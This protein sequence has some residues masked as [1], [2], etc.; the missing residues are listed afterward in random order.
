[1]QQIRATTAEALYLK[2]SDLHDEIEPELETLLLET[3]WT[4]EGVGEVEAQLV[5]E[6]LAPN[7][8]DSH[9]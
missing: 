4:D 9:R 5:V 2:L 3:A 8:F 6:L 1:M 7:D